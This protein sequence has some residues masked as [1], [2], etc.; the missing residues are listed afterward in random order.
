MD[1]PRFCHKKY[2]FYVTKCKHRK[3]YSAKKAAGRRDVLQ[4]ER[5]GEEDFCQGKRI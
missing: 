3:E 4:G 2:I 5:G 1:T